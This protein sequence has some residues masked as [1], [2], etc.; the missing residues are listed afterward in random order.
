[1]EQVD[2]LIRIGE[3][4]TDRRLEGSLDF[5]AFQRLFREAIAICGSD[6]DRLEMFC[7]F[8]QTAQWREWMLAEMREHSAR[9]VA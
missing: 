9:R 3:E 5:P 6:S 4:L 2:A 8:I 1:M 7:P